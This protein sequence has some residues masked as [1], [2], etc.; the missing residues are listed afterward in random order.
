M[1]INELRMLERASRG[2]T[3][4]P[5]SVGDIISISYVIKFITF[6]FEGICICLRKKK[7]KNMNSTFILRNNLNGIGVE[8][9]MAYFY[10]RAYNFGVADHSRK[11]YH[12]NKS[13]LFFLRSG[14][15]K[16]SKV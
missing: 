9:T 3:S 2:I 15:N 10:N 7:I 12:Y 16:A 11:K 1:D 8:L 13:R 4:P 6:G 5:F 14:L